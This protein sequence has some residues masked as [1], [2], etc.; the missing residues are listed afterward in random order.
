MC[1]PTDDAERQKQGSLHQ[2]EEVLMNFVRFFFGTPRRLVVSLIVIVLITVSEHFAPGV[3]GNVVASTLDKTLGA[4]LKVAFEALGPLFGAILP[5][6]V[7]LVG[8]RI[9]FKGFK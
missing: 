3:L 7:V 2:N 9:L 1:V 4:V 8:F 5:I 6:I